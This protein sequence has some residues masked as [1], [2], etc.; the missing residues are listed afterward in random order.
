M[1]FT[2]VRQHPFLIGGGVLLGALALFALTR[3]GG[4]STSAAAGVDPTTAALWAQQQQQ[5]T[6]LTAQ[7]NQIAGQIQIAG[8]QAQYG[9]NIAQINA[10]TDIAKINSDT[11][12]GTQSIAAQLE[13]L[14]L[15]NTTQ[16]Y[17]IAAQLEGLLSNNATQVNLT[18]IVA[19]EQTDLARVNADV[20]KTQIN[21]MKDI[22]NKKTSSNLLGN[23]IGGV[24]G[25][26]AA[27][28]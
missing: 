18:Q 6:A 21:A 5:Q 17:G 3:G 22:A 7:N 28:L 20:M 14:K 24:A 27:F 11:S 4:G 10:N 8:L 9:Q 26:A 16:Q 23:I 1:D 2:Y 19:N 13:G 12:L 25:V 15:Q